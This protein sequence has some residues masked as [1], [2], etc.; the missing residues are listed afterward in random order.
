MGG[1][2]ARVAAGFTTGTFDSATKQYVVSDTDAHDWV[3][4]WFARYGWVTFDPTPASAPA[5]GGHAPLPAVPGSDAGVPTAPLIH[6]QA[7]LPGPTPGVKAPRPRASSGLAS[8]MRWIV[9]GA[10]LVIA[11]LAMLAWRL[12]AARAGDQ[13]AEL[14]RALRRC[15]RPVA[16]GV[17][18]AAL[19]RRFG[20]SGDAAAYIRAIRLARFAGGQPPTREQRR[21]LRA[22]LRAGL[23]WTGA[24]R[25]LWALPPRSPFAGD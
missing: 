18:L 4:A 5:R 23:G 13:L 12:A 21:A 14:E 9:L 17:T 15:G 7:E 8:V 3:E 25:A 16:D 24:M 6:H 10:A 2:P 20:S 11:L 19:E 1:V 22:Q